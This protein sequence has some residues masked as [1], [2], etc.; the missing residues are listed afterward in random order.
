MQLDGVDVRALIRRKRMGLGLEASE[1]AGL[2]RSFLVGTV[3]EAQMA[4]L[5]MAGVIRGFTADEAVALTAAMVES[6]ET[7][8]LSDL[9]GPTVD[10]HSTGGVGDTTT[11]VVGPL[12]AACGLQMAKLSGRALG[13]TGGTLDK[14]EAIP[15]MRVQLSP[16]AF[17]AQVERVGVAVAAASE[18]LVPA[19]KKIYAL[20]DETDTVENAGLIAASVMSKKI[21]GGA[22]HIVLD[23]KTGDGA[24]M[25]E[26]ARA[27]ELAR[28][29]LQ[30]GEAHGRRMAALVTDMSQPL[31]RAVGNALEVAEA[32]RV[33]QNVEQGRLTQL[34]LE[35]V[36]ALLMLA[37]R[38]PEDARRATESALRSGAALEKF[39][40][41]VATQGGDPTVADRPWSVLPRAAVRTAWKTGPGRVVVIECRRLGELAQRLSV[42]RG[43]AA[44]AT[45]PAVGLEVLVSLGQE[46]EAGDAAVVVHARTPSDAQT[47][48]SYLPECVHLEGGRDGVPPG[49]GDAPPL[50]HDAFG[51]PSLP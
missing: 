49:Y 33:L 38:T 36:T 22:G 11:L 8:D 51:I 15:G 20:R 37:G 27:Q 46:L 6:G 19:D 12:A 23:V 16:A 50:V 34:C 10:K 35:L 24:F 2:V 5:L 14:L 7:I 25:T 39:R 13:H 40:Q 43:G 3:S 47:A 28:L 30:L 17:K 18:R 29:C 4:A 42:G 48:M 26:I 45:D 32:V 31:G 21:A 1:V 9:S 41:W 44:E